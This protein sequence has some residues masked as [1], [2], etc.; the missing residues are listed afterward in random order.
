M[1]SEEFAKYIQDRVDG[2]FDR[3]VASEVHRLGCIDEYVDETDHEKGIIT[4]INLDQLTE[5]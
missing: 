1:V 3:Q 4:C 2:G 5:T